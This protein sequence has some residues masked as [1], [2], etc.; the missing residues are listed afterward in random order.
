MFREMCY[1]MSSVTGPLPAG[2]ANTSGLTGA[3]AENMFRQMCQGMSGVTG[4]LPAGFANTSGLTGAPA[5]NMY[6]Y[7]CY[8]MSSVTGPLPAG[9]ANTSGLTGAPAADMYTRMCQGMSSIASGNI[10]IGENLTL[11]ATN[12]AAL[13]RMMQ[14]C[15]SWTGEVFWGSDLLVDQVTPST[16]IQTFDG[17]N[18]MPGYADIHANW[19]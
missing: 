5:A 11:D 7:M 16:R 8:G 18:N 3:P 1:G 17:C 9:F 15:G 12:V 4:P 2:F 13:T 19:K 6:F 10:I 14:G